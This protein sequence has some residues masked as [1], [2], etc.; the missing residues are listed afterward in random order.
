MSPTY[1]EQYISTLAAALPGSS[2]PGSWAVHDYSDVTRAY[3]GASLTDLEAF[4]RALGSDT[5]GRAKDLWITEAG[6]LL[7]SRTKLG[8]CPA[9]GT[10]PAGTVGACINGNAAAQRA[11]IAAFFSLPQA[12]VSVP[13]THLFWYEWQGG[14]DWDSGLV[15]A[16]GLPRSAW[17]AFFGSG[18]CTGSPNA[19]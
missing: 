19:P 7:N 12:G 8:S 9:N 2:F 13:I 5:G 6:M 16:A 10:D 17:C 4:D 14:I 11:D 15:D 18:N 1:L 3:L